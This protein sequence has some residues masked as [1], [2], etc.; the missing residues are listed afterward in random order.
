MAVLPI[1]HEPK[2]KLCSHD[3]RPDIDAILELRSNLGVDDGGNR[4]NLVYVLERFAEWG[5]VNPTADNVKNHWRKHCQVIN[6]EAM[7]AAQSAALVELERMDREGVHVDVNRDLDWMWGIGLA[8][9]RGRVARGEKSGITPD[10]LMKVAAEK[11]RRQHNESQD[12]LLKALTGGVAEAFTQ[13]GRG[14]KA[15]PIPVEVI[16]AVEVE[17]EEVA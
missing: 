3:R 17:F 13:L 14:P 11:T 15:L 6:S 7:E 9:I 16:E 8:E 2:C 10:M 5:V 4:V 1:K 12:E